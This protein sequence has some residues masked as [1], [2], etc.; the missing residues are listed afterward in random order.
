MSNNEY[1]INK[2]FSHDRDVNYNNNQDYDKQN[3]V[4]K[5]TGYEMTFKSP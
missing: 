3:I 2:M 5:N 4:N 1:A